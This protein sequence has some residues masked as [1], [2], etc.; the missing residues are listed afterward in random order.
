MYTVTT[1]VPMPVP[2][3]PVLQVYSRRP[4]PAAPVPALPQAPLPTSVPTP[5]P[6]TTS[7]SVDPV[8]NDTLPIAVRK[9]KRS[10]TYP[11]SSFASYAQLSSVSCSFVA[12]LDSVSIPK[13]VKE[14]LS[15]P[16]WR[17]AMIE[18]MN[19]LDHNDT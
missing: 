18:E 3:P 10:C 7:K 4:Q 1:S 2:T 5:I 12:S 9:G 6:D 13:T 16:G 15:H 14:A 8:L 11:I 19:A 17:T